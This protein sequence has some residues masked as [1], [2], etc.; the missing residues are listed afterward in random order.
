MKALAI[1]LLLIL[2]VWMLGPAVWMLKY[3]IT[4]LLAF[5]G[6]LAIVWIVVSLEKK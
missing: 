5:I 2:A 4:R 6:V 3:V 1:V